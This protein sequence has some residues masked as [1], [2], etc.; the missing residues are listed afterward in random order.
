MLS[1]A[2]TQSTGSDDNQEVSQGLDSG[3]PASYT[4]TSPV[5]VAPFIAHAE[6]LHF[7]LCKCVVVGSKG[8]GHA[9]VVITTCLADGWRCKAVEC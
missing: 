6:P 3:R 9:V 1:S 5:V 8:S 4:S 2:I 7:V